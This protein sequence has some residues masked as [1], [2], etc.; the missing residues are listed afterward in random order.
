MSWRDGLTGSA[1]NIAQVTADVL[2]VMAGPGSGKTFA[3]KRRVAR[4]LDD[5]VDAGRILAVTFTRTAASDLVKELCTLGE[6]GCENIRACTLHSFCFSLLSK[7][8]IFSYL[9]RNPRPL[10]FF[11][12]SGVMQFEGA[13][14]LQDLISFGGKRDCTKRIRAFEAAWARLQSESPGWPL[15]PIDRQFH[16]ALLDWLR[17]HEGM[18]IGEL[19]PETLRYL[20]NNPTC[21]VLNEFDHVIV[22]EY[23]DLNKAEQVL[24]DILASN[25]ALAVVG[26]VDQSIYSFRHA[27]PQGII[28]FSTSHP[29]THDENLSECRRCPTRVVEIA[30]Y[31]IQHNHPSA[32]VPRL[33]PMP[34]NIEGDVYITQ[35]QSLDEEAN[36]IAEFVKHLIT[37]RDYS[38]G[39]ILILSP[40]RLIGYGIRDALVA[41]NI[42][43]HSFYHEEALEDDEAQVAFNLLALL[44]NTEDRVALRFWLGYGHRTWRHKEYLILRTHCEQSGVSPWAA[45]QQMRYGALQLSGMNNL[46]MRFE[47]LREKL[48]TIQTLT[49][50]AL[51]DQIFP[52]NE[53]WARILREAALLKI[54]DATKPEELL[55]ILR[56]VITQ[57]EMPETGNFVRV[58]SLHKSKGLTSKVVLIAGC[59]HGLIPFVEDDHTPAERE[60]SLKEQRRL[61]YVAITRPKEILV[62]SSVTRLERRLAHK[63]GAKLQGGTGPTGRTIASSFISELGPSAPDSQ[64]GT[65]WLR[66]FS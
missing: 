5:G 3:M 62:V 18:L 50:T 49:G 7:T 21:D 35:W 52:E 29:G 64:V 2:R 56:N 19:I 27:H 53:N 32:G 8:E 33:L 59:V 31:L 40:R 66:G 61:F 28:E 65:N 24:L 25:S 20:R 22:D 10:V 16:Q 1:L 43:T 34:G 55:D 6:P 58:M 11:N 37:N 36:G 17:F 46:L 23:Q 63:I 4:L 48:E 13:P 47:Q 51:V 41:L 57:P 45:L 14:M 12:K 60:I 39:D 26:D 9:N 30:N 38:P 54:T 15:N 44:A 42:P